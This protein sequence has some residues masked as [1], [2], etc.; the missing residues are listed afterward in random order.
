MSHQSHLKEGETSCFVTK[1]VGST[2]VVEAS[3]NV[4]GF[5]DDT[6]AVAIFGKHLNKKILSGAQREV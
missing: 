4:A 3:D 5:E 6:F 1:N 2:L